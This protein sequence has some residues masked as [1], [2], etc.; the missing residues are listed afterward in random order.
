MQRHPVEAAM[1]SSHYFKTL[2]IPWR[3]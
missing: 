3:W 2:W 1:L